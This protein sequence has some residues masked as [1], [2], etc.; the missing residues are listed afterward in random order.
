MYSTIN[1]AILRLISSKI[2]KKYLRVRFFNEPEFQV[3]IYRG[4]SSG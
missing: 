1:L 4:D 2:G 3:E